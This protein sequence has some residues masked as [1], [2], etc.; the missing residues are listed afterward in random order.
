MGNNPEVML[1]G[2]ANGPGS[3][4]NLLVSGDNDY[5]AFSTGQ[6]LSVINEIYPTEI[7]AFHF[8]D[9]YMGVLV[10]GG[11]NIRRTDY[12]GSSWDIVLPVDYTTNFV[13]VNDV[14]TSET[15]KALLVG[16]K[17][18]NPFFVEVD[19]LESS[20]DFDGD[21]DVDIDDFNEIYSASF[22]IP[23]GS[24]LVLRDIDINPDVGDFGYMVGNNSLMFGLNYNGIDPPQLDFIPFFGTVGLPTSYDMRAVHSFVNGAAMVVGEDKAFLFRGGAW[25]ENVTP[26]GLNGLELMD[27]YWRDDLNGYIVGKY[28]DG[29]DDR[30]LFLRSVGVSLTPN[31]PSGV[32]WSSPYNINNDIVNPFQIDDNLVGATINHI[33]MPTKYDGVFAGELSS[34]FF[35]P[36]PYPYVR[37]FHDE[38]QEY[39]THFYYDKL[40]RL[41]LS[42]NVKQHRQGD[43]SLANEEY[44]Y[45]RYD[46]LNRIV[47]TGVIEDT[48]GEFYNIFGS[49]VG[50]AFNANVIDDLQLENF[51]AIGVKREVSKTIYDEA[52]EFGSCTEPIVQENLRN[53]VASRIYIDDMSAPLNSCQLTDAENTVHDYDNA[54]HYSYDIHGNVN[55]MYVEIG[56]LNE[57][58]ANQRLKKIDYKYDLVSGNV[59]EVIYQ[60]GLP[61]MFA[62]R[63]SYDAENRIKA[64]MT[65]TDGNVWDR[66]GKYFYYDHGPLARIE[67]GENQV[68][69]SDFAYTLQGWLKGMNSTTLNADRDMGHDGKAGHVNAG[70]A[71]DVYGMSL[72]YYN[73]ANNRDYK[74]IDEAGHWTTVDTRFESE[75][76]S[77]DLLAERH[78]LYNGNIGHSVNT[79]V[80]PEDMSPQP[81]GNGYV[82][83]QL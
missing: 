24:S 12:V 36:T 69:G 32:G 74:P 77:S 48:N 55:S 25:E 15:G 72:G 43:G 21:M 29:D 60:D 79:L 19:Q 14:F 10:L 16:K 41:V 53:R 34:S 83:D 38:S 63:Y 11:H 2:I 3:S 82:Y 54:I 22:D 28:N 33:E 58:D 27:V 7:E 64:V 59:K 39:S 23:S 52:A 62:H 37:H 18:T 6:S 80:N 46:E 78:N 75:V 8:A 81:L 68:Q 49:G 66:D 35:N 44:A 47:E 13:E 65:S 73:D 30:P 9:P 4:Q 51:L 71:R 26:F 40:G 20:G 45:T 42:Q 5:L 31:G 50:G 70:F 1:R 61:D 76:L 56:S 17:S 57:L 67:V